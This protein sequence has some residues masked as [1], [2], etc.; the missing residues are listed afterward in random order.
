MKEIVCK[1]TEIINAKIKGEI[2][3]SIIS[4]EKNC[5]NVEPIQQKERNHLSISSNLLKLAKNKENNE[6][7]KMSAV[8]KF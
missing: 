5:S 1:N 7:E 4:I 2:L 6:N 3:S 8:C